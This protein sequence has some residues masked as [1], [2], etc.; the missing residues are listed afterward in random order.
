MK[1][2]WCDE[3][4]IKRNERRANTRE[5]IRSYKLE[6][7]CQRCGYNESAYALDA[8]HKDKN[9]EFL[10]GSSGGQDVSIERLRVEL[11]KCDIL[12]ANC[13]RIEHSPKAP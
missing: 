7:G 9:K 2:Y 12:C 5:F 6:R 8:H 11:E 4:R 13:H 3:Y 10:I 1:K